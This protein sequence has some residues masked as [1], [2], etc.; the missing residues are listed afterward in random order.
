MNTGLQDAYNLGWKLALVTAGRAS[1]SLLESY[2]SE[3]LPVARRLLKTTDQAFSLIVSDRWISRIL[4]TRLLSRIVSFAMRFDRIQKV[5]FRTISQIGIRYRQSLLSENLQG[6]PGTGPL[7]GDRFPWVKLKF[8]PGGSVED[9]FSR[10]DDTH[11]NL[12][13]IGQPPL[14]SEPP[15]VAGLLNTHA[16]AADPDNDQE[17]S[18]VRIPNPS[19]YLLRPDGYIGLCGTRLDG[20]TVKR[21]LAERLMLRIR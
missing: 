3:R 12:I 5:A 11:F 6:L 8:S 10:I 13:V 1:E 2:E 16:V 14:S 21:Y 4:R 7:A 15:E 19:F 17:L 20:G 18:R 9:L